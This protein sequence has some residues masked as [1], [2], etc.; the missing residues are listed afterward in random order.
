MEWSSLSGIVVALIKAVCLSWLRGVIFSSGLGGTSCCSIFPQES[1]VAA[2]KQPLWLHMG[3]ENWK[4]S[5]LGA[6]VPFQRARLSCATAGH[7]RHWS[8]SRMGVECGAVLLSIC[9]FSNNATDCSWSTTWS[10]FLVIHCYKD[11][12][13]K[14]L[15]SQLLRKVI[16]KC[17]NT[18]WLSPDS[19]KRCWDFAGVVAS[20]MVLFWL[21]LAVIKRHRFNSS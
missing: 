19:Q 14:I 4:N 6:T 5:N 7:G 13:K 3:K 10:C 21:L 20:E 16:L 9:V 11:Q 2:S 12:Q 1:T 18:A 8:V 15:K 17:Q